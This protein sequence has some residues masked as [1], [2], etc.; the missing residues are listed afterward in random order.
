MKKFTQK[1]KHCSPTESLRANEHRAEADSG[2]SSY[3]L[4]SLLGQ[5]DFNAP[6][7]KDMQA[8]DHMRSVGREF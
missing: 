8:W 7:P 3:D 1:L 2:A 6:Q 4:A 5:C